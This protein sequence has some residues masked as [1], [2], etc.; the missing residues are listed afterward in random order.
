MVN[1]VIMKPYAIEIDITVDHLPAHTSDSFLMLLDRHGK[2]RVNTT[3]RGFTNELGAIASSYSVTGDFVFIGKNKH[4]ILLAGKR[5]KE[6][7]GGIV[8]VHQGEVLLEIPLALRGMMFKGEM[9]D[10]IA[11]EK[12]LKRHL[13]NFG[14]PFS[15]PVYSI[16]FL[17]S[18]HLPYVR[19][20]PQGIIDVKKKELLFPATMC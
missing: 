12:E 11:K 6:L 10:L 5:L 9:T 20:T 1:D 19:I 4:D 18:T 13:K 16:F 2:W 17:A 8:I 14:Y 3:L 15:D 7:G